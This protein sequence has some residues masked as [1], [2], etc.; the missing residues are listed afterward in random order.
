M[1]NL[2]E[3]LQAVLSE[4]KNLSAKINNLE[5]RIGR[6]E[7]NLSLQ[8]SVQP[9]MEAVAATPAKV[10]TPKLEPTDGHTFETQIGIGW[11]GKIG[12]I[13]I[14]IGI[15]YFLQYSI[16]TSVFNIGPVGRVVIGLL[17]GLA[18]L[19]FGEFFNTRYP[20]W[21]REFTGGGL[22]LLYFSFFT[23]CNSD[24]IIPF[25]IGLVLMSLV[26]MT[27]GWF[28]I[29]YKTKV[30]ATFGLIGGYLTPWLIGFDIPNYNRM[31]IYVLL[32]NI[33]VLFFA[34]FQRWRV[35]NAIAL[36]V[37]LLYS[38]VSLSHLSFPIA[39]SYILIFFAL[40]VSLAIIYNLSKLEKT[41]TEDLL[42]LIFNPLIMMGQVYALFY[43]YNYDNYLGLISIVF[44]LLYLLLAY[45]SLSRNRED[46][47]LTYSLT[48]VCAAFVALAIALQLEAGWIT[49]AW[50]MQ[51]IAMLWIGLHLRQY[52]TRV[53]ALIVGLLAVLRLWFVDIIQSS[54]DY[55]LKFFNARFLI[56]LF[57]IIMIYVG[58]YL[59]KH[60][61]AEI[62]KGERKF[63]TILVILASLG[64]VYLVSNEIYLYFTQRVSGLIPTRS[65][66]ADYQQYISDYRNYSS[67][68]RLL[69]QKAQ[70]FIST[71]WLL[72]AILLVIV[73]I[74]KK[75]RA[76]RLLALILFFISILKIVIYDLTGFDAIYRIIAFIILGIAL[77]F[78]SYLYTK[79]KEKILAFIIQKEDIEDVTRM[80]E[81]MSDH[82]YNSVVF[83]LKDGSRFKVVN[84]NVVKIIYAV[85]T[86]FKRNNFEPGELEETY[87]HYSKNFRS[88]LNARDL[89]AVKKYLYSFVKAGG[90][91]ELNV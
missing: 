73:G 90:S 81:E 74:V 51:F 70:I 86:K 46:K 13:A 26:T 15:A 22:G 54:N 43:K 50:T 72:Y 76:I 84:K 27:C 40:F 3:P 64:T 47:Y 57:V 63:V 71:F 78:A 37:T 91:F 1:P 38:S 77:I 19:G 58:A 33:G 44:A 87:Q 24:R 14:A 6:I 85:Q 42:I 75:F 39:L 28:S 12:I 10:E 23:A 21:S 20:Q 53:Y 67:G 45:Y 48:G 5:S 41:S 82:G 2:N 55:D 9:A 60:Y 32:L 8:D 18:M 11:L 7:G 34:Y 30:I 52:G 56:G 25:G 36:V 65:G 59:Y 35:L 69:N 4:L 29:R 79:N 17:A 49:I 62:D 68:R 31:L 66:Y 88:Q 83:T 61:K 80:I 16:N 89:E